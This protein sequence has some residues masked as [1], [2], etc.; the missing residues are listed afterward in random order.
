M[1]LVNCI[2]PD[3]AIA[4]IRLIGDNDQLGSSI[5]QRPECFMDSGKPLKFF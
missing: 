2:L 3:N 4:H 5:F 1:H